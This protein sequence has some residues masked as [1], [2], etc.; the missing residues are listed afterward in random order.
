LPALSSHYLH[1]TNKK[2]FNASNVLFETK[3]QKGLAI[4]LVLEI[5]SRA[6]YFQLYWYLVLTIPEILVNSRKQLGLKDF[7]V[8]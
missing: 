5:L 2:I 3:Y 6:L 8:I 4:G 7:Y 1:K